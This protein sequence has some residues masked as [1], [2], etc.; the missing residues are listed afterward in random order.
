MGEIRFYNIDETTNITV[1]KYMKPNAFKHQNEIR[2]YV[3]DTNNAP[4]LVK[5]GSI[6]AVASIHKVCMINIK[7]PCHRSYCC[8]QPLGS[9]QF[10]YIQ[11]LHTNQV[12]L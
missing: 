6:S 3:E 12:P 2:Y 4:L 11:V 7:L 10:L 5:I 8:L 9:T 1:D